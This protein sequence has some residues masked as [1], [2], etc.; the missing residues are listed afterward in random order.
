MAR[1]GLAESIHKTTRLAHTDVCGTC[2]GLCSLVMSLWLVL[3]I[4]VGRG[5]NGIRDQ[6]LA[7][8]WVQ[9][10]IRSFGG[11]PERVLLFGDPSYSSRP[12]FQAAAVRGTRGTN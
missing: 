1:Q 4:P 7:L 8:E 2:S 11:D 9:R 5:A 3:Q 10:N 12:T 6:L